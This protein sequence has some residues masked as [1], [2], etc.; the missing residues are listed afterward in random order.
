MTQKDFLD[1]ILKC[2]SE[3]SEMRKLFNE[4][5][6]LNVE[7]ITQK[8]TAAY[9]RKI[10]ESKITDFGNKLF[11]LSRI[12]SD[13][14]NAANKYGGINYETKANNLLEKVK[15]VMSIYEEVLNPSENAN[16]APNNLKD[17]GSGEQGDIQRT[18]SE[19]S[20][21]KNQLNTS[22]QSFEDRSA[23]ILTNNIS[24]LG[25]FVAIAFA[26][27]GVMSIFPQIDIRYA[28]S[29]KF[30]FIKTSFFLLLTTLLVYNL[31]LFLV[32]FIFKLSR[33]FI[34]RSK[35]NDEKND[36]S[37]QFSNIIKLKPF[38]IIDIIMLIL[39]VVLF[40]WSLKA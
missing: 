21:L 34:E 11:V 28:I 9:I 35:K 6:D 26:G 14:K 8:E 5:K 23:S 19:I 33:P 32:Y 4:L 38:V 40:F 25:I 10:K 31:L 20:D 30:G 27:F 17:F 16:K 18:F 12:C 7:N 15:S 29:S 39:T 24:I 22:K 2:S 36:K 37:E 13:E 3:E 1:A